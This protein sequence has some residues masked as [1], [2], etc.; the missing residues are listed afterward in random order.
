MTTFDTAAAA[1]ASSA[2]W[3]R[4][5]LETFAAVTIV[6]GAIA[7]IA[8]LVRAARS[9]THIS[10]TGARLSL[11]RYLALALELQ[12]AADLVATAIA[13][14]WQELGQLAVIAAIRTFLNYF[15]SREMNDERAALDSI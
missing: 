11:A 12:L 10:F 9:R 8:E 15:L 2:E 6:A 3:V 1:I 5:G 13:P 7:M 4:L 14:D